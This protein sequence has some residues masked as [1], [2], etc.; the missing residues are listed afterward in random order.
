VWS[1][2]QLLAFLG[3]PDWEKAI[4]N[5]VEELLCAKNPLTPDLGGTATTGEVGDEIIRRIEAL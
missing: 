3:Y 5:I 4:L 2:A 1:C